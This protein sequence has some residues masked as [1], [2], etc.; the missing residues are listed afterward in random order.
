MLMIETLINLDILYNRRIER[1]PMRNNP[2]QNGSFQ[3]FVSSDWALETPFISYK[4]HMG[5]GDGNSW[6]LEQ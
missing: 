6:G 4:G 1:L 2:V 3:T 5:H